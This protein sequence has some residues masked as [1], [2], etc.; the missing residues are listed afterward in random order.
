VV[1]GG[2]VV[3]SRWRTVRLDSPPPPGS[4]AQV[5][6]VPDGASSAQVLAWADECLSEPARSELH[7]LLDAECEPPG[8]AL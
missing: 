4:Q 2:V 1:V 8:A 6:A 5:L 3:A 7:A